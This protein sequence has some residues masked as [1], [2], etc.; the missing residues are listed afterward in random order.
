MPLDTGET[1]R[2]SAS[3]RRVAIRRRPFFKAC[4]AAC[5]VVLLC[6]CSHP[7]TSQVSTR[8]AAPLG[9]SAPLPGA[10]SPIQHYINTEW[11]F[12]ID[13]PDGWTTSDGFAK[14]Y[15]ANDSWKTFASPDSQGTPIVALVMPGSNSV[16]DA[17]IRIGAS[18]APGAIVNCMQP[19][20]A[21][22]PGSVSLHEIQGVPFT[23][24]DAA[25]AAMS[26]HLKV[27]AY[28]AMHNGTC[29]AI[30]LLVF[31]TNPQVYSPPATPPFSDAEAFAAM[32]EI[33]TSFRF[34]R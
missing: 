6:S 9:A 11:S 17:E 2:R 28:R 8:S 19:P 30:D 32:H 34:T 22:R 24:F 27:H 10:S 21:A 29:Y 26:H 7:D 33:L 1:T 23:A 15:L 13:L 20:A 16:S 14:S 18:H 31:G 12:R 5:S 4:V 25:D 3:G